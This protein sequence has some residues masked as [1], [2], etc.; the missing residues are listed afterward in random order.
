MLF[1]KMHWIPMCKHDIQ[2][3]VSLSLLQPK[4]IDAVESQRL[5]RIQAAR[6]IKR[7]KS[8]HSHRSYS[9]D[10]RVEEETSTCLPSCFRP[11]QRSDRDHLYRSRNDTSVSDFPSPDSNPPSYGEG[12]F[13]SAT[14]FRSRSWS[15]NTKSIHEDS[16]ENREEQTALLVDLGQTQP[17]YTLFVFKFS[18]NCT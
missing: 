18:K 6:R 3:H 16:I 14:E 1:H 10:S 7:T 9:V 13:Q 12:A 15:S 2:R 5:E 8:A 17:R 4:D 11:H